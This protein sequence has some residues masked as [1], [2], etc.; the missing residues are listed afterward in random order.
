MTMP[1]W[2]YNLI[3]EDLE[4]TGPRWPPL[5]PTTNYCQYPPHDIFHKTKYMTHNRA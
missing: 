2:E 4:G 1:I 5:T 3:Q